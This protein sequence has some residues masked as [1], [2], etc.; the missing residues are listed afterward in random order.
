MKEQE[1]E[2][3]MHETFVDE[4]RLI[5]QTNNIL[6]ITLIHL[7]LL[8]YDVIKQR[9]VLIERKKNLRALRKAATIF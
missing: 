9:N 5:S 1:E 6:L 2:I 7:F 4:T 3:I 8:H